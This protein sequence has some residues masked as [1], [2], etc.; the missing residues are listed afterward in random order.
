MSRLILIP[1]LV[2]V[3]ATSACAVGPQFESLTTPPNVRWSDRATGSAPTVVT[4]DPDPAWWEQFHD[5]ILDDLIRRAVAGNLDLQRALT[6]IIEARQNIAVA[7][8]AG[9]PTLSGNGKYS[10]EQAGLRGILQSQGVPAAV[11]SSNLSSDARKSVDGALVQVEQ[12]IN[13]FQYS[14]DASWEIDLFGRIRRSVE[15]AQANSEVQVE[16]AKDALVMLEAQVGQAYGTLR[17][18]QALIKAQSIN[19][20]SAQTSLQLALRRRREGIS[21]DLDVEQARTT[22]LDF[23]RQLPAYATQAQIAKN[24]LAVLI[25]KRPGELNPL[26]DV[27]AAIPETSEVV[28]IGIPATLARRRPDIRQAEANLHAATANIGV[29]TAMF[30]PDFTLSGSF[31]LRAIDASYVANWASQFYSVGPSITVPIFQGGKLTANLKLARAQQ[32]EAALNYRSTVLNALQEVEN[33]LVTYRNDI[34][35]REK[36]RGVVAS[37]EYAFYLSQNR[38]QNGLVDFTNVLMTELTVT[39]GRQNLAQADVSLFGD[40]VTLYRALGGGWQ[41]AQ[42]DFIQPDNA[43]HPQK[44]AAFQGGSSSSATND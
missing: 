8:A 20:A 35:T 3:V 15:Q 10:R 26:L 9:L 41:P 32:Q 21:S 42:S 1:A 43:I 38:Y 12:P 25:G 16:G 29:A 6:R 34:A 5:P 17:G 30:Y 18:A 40:V 44:A 27:D 23:Q 31:G 37:A 13:L 2:S 4:T 36:L 33:S 22:L 39:T 7:G 11:D 14:A 24:Q 19:I 28:R